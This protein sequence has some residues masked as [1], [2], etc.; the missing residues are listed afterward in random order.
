MMISKNQLLQ[1]H[2]FFTCFKLQA[3]LAF[4]HDHHRGNGPDKPKIMAIYFSGLSL[5]H[6]HRAQSSQTSRFPYWAS[7][8]SVFFAQWANA[9]SNLLPTTYRLDKVN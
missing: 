5:S 1:I 7:N 3:C 2:K 9:Q 4:C 6:V 8:F